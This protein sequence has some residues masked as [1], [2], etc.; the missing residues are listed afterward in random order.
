MYL[1]KKIDLKIILLIS[2]AMCL[3]MSCA[4]DD[5]KSDASDKNDGMVFVEAGE[6]LMGSD[7]GYNDEKPIHRVHVDAFYIDRYEVTNA[8]YCEF[9]NQKGNQQEGGA[10]WVNMNSEDCKITTQENKYVPLNGYT[11][12][13]VVMVTW[14]G[15]RAY[16]AWAGKRLPTEAEWECA[17]KGGIFPASFSASYTYSGSNQPDEVAWYNNNA[18]GTPHPVGSKKAN[19]L[20]IH[21]MSGNVWEWCADWLDLEYYGA[22]PYKNPTGP[23]TGTFRVTR[24]GS[25]DDA[26]NG[27]RCACRGGSVPNACYNYLGFRCAR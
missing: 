27:V 19:E 7:D 21:D 3:I 22:S 9:L 18:G 15:A 8:Q 23:A 10:N 12:H 1:P 11:D 4:K 14:Y 24:G 13:P 17:C 26:A 2:C 20:G 5:S 25:W 16:A 6:F